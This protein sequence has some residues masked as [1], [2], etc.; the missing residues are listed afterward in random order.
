MIINKVGLPTK[1]KR[2]RHSQEMKKA[3]TGEPSY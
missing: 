2:Y 3:P 1:L